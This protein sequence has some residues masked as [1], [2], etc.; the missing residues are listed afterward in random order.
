MS[1]DLHHCTARLSKYE[2]LFTEATKPNLPA[3]AATSHIDQI[4]AR[5]TCFRHPAP[6]PER[7]LRASF[8]PR[9][10]RD[11]FC[12]QITRNLGLLPIEL[13][14]LI[15]LRFVLL[16]ASCL[17][18]TF[19]SWDCSAT[20]RAASQLLPKQRRGGRLQELNPQTSTC[21]LTATNMASFDPSSTYSMGYH[22]T[23]ELTTFEHRPG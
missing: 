1:L 16:L 2:I 4:G 23:I 21:A 22:R 10:D 5:I 8:S 18:N 15:I 14:S 17:G 12:L 7:R 9:H 3:Y 13:A 6:S 20:G 11:L 19:R